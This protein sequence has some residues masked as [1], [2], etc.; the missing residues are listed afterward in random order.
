MAPRKGKIPDHLKG[1]QFKKGE[2]KTKTASA[3]GGK[4]SRSKKSS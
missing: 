3:K 1:F 4:K 2:K